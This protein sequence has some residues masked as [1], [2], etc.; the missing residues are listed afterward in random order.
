MIKI[1]SLKKLPFFALILLL[2]ASSL[3]A[4]KISKDEFNRLRVTEKLLRAQ[5]SEMESEFESSSSL[6]KYRVE[7][8]AS[9]AGKKPIPVSENAMAKHLE[10]AQYVF[11]GDEHTTDESQRNTIAVLAMMLKSKKPVTLVIEWID[12][13]YQNDVNLYLAGKTT[14]KS[15]R[16]KVEF[17]KHWGFSW[18]SYSKILS[19]AKKMKVPVLLVERLKNRHSLAD[20]DSYIAKAIAR[21]AASNKNMRYLTVYGEYH[22]LGPDH[23]TDKCAKLGLKPQTI[24]VGDAPEV[25][26]KLLGTIKDPEKVVFA[27]LRSN[28]FYIRNGTPLERSFSYRSYLMKILGWDQSDFSDEISASDI[29]PEAAASVSN[30]FDQLHSPT[31]R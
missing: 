30:R 13:S 16:S 5:I 18:A 2:S 23:L 22:L 31:A 21:D 29:V 1:K 4:A 7:Y 26:W 14:L 20:R 3:Y 15:M 10:K 17:D 25:Y 28:V 19:A 6:D 11:L 24:L 12:D 9:V 27:Q 8:L